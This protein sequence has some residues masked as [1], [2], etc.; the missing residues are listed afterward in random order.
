MG[1]MAVETVPGEPVSGPG[2]TVAPSISPVLAERC[3]AQMEVAVAGLANAA[4]H[5]NTCDPTDILFGVQ[6]IFDFFRRRLPRE[7]KT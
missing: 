4:I 2:P 3:T 1:K 7:W 5:A 6:A